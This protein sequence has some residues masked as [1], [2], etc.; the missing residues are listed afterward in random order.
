MSAIEFTYNEYPTIGV[1][2]ELQ[3]VD[4]ESLAL[5]STIADILAGVPEKHSAHFKPELMQCCLEINTGVCRTVAEVEADLTAKLALADKLADAAG[6]RLFWAGTHPFSSWHDQVVTPDERY[7]GLVDLLQDTAR[8]L[9]TFGLHVH[10][11]VDTG[12]KAVMICERIQ[13]HLP[14]LLALSSNSPFWNSRPTGLQSQRS[15]LMDNLPTAGL[16]PLMRNWSEYVWL[17]NHLVGTG[18]INTIREIWW[19]VRPHNNF[20]TVEVRICDVPA[21]LTDVLGLT[22]VVQ[23]L[24]HALSEEIDAG[25]YQHDCHPTMVRQNKWRACRHGMDANLVDLW[26]QASLP[27]RKMLGQL[28]DRLHE[29]AVELDCLDYLEHARAMAQQPTGAERQLAV[30]HETGDLV[31]VVR[32]CLAAS[33]A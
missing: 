9:I 10:V 4:A 21:S 18:F 6:S 29:T 28:V 14:T 3:L 25:T 20:G 26:T 30:Y 27:A 22:A 2:I 31:E 33:G 1:E 19:D 5:K 17:V 24:V 11:G 15:K 7:H 32:R 8:R 13:N 12:D 23:C 16:P